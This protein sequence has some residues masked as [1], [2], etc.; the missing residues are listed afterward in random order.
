MRSLVRVIESLTPPARTT[1]FVGYVAMAAAGQIDVVRELFAFSRADTSTSHIVLIPA[2]SALLLFQGRTGVF[3]SVNI[4]WRGG[5]AVIL[6]GVML[7]LAVNMVGPLAGPADYLRLRVVGLL[8]MWVGGF[9]LLFGWRALKEARFALA[10]LVFTIPIPTALMDGIIGGLKRGSTEAVAALFTL[11]GTPYHR[12]GFVF[13]LPR[14]TIEVA[15]ECSGIRSTIALVLTT[16]LAGHSFLKSGW[17]KALLL[18]AIVPITILKNGVR[19]VSLSLLATYVD[20]SFLV[21]RLHHDGGIVFFILGLALL[22]PVLA[23]LRQRDLL[24]DVE[25]VRASPS[26]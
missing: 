19:I 22:V 3:A 23:L 5:M 13:S 20:P 1:L 25:A 8:M 9:L 11:T 16:L 24:R 2:I 12:E 10:F 15:D 17:S 26:H 14:F 6:S 4:A 21:G 7:A 18:V